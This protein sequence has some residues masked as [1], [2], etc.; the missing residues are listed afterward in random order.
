MKFEKHLPIGPWRR[1]VLEACVFDNY[2]EFRAALAL[3]RTESVLWWIRN[4]PVVL[5]IPTP[6][7]GFEPDFLYLRNPSNRIIRGALEVK[8]D[9]LW[10]APEQPDRIKALAAAEWIKKANEIC[11]GEPWEL[12]V[13]G[14]QE[15]KTATHIGDLLAAAAGRLYEGPG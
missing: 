7:G 5:S 8:G 9:F 3:D 11:P 15:A 4:D 2:Q 6:V 13:V 1:C 10:S 12:A 14:D